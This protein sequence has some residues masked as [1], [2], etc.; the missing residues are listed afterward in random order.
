MTNGNHTGANQH[1]QHKRPRIK[2]PAK[3]EFSTQKA[4]EQRVETPRE[5]KK[6]NL[7]TNAFR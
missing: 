2:Q 4:N 5:P 6:P 1:N 7:F 3:M